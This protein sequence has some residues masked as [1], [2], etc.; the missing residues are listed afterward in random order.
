MEVWKCD[1]IEYLLRFIYFILCGF[2]WYLKDNGV[3]DKNFFDENNGEFIDF[4]K[5]VDV[6]MKFLIDKGFGCSLK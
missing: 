5:L 6:R 2:L 4:W 3:Y 1:G